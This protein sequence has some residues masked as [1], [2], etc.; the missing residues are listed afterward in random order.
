L[1]HPEYRANRAISDIVATLRAQIV[2][3]G[4]GRTYLEIDSSQAV[5]EPILGLRV[6]VHLERLIVTRDYTLLL[7]PPE[8]AKPRSASRVPTQKALAGDA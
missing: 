7:N 8:L 4:N 5:N 2:T 6:R 3:P 1:P